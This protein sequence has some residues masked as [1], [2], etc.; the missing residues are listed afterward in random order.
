MSDDAIIFHI[1][2]DQDI[3]K[4]QAQGEYRCA[5]LDSEGFIHC[6]DRHQLA[7]VVNRYYQDSD[8]VQ[9]MLLDPDKL[10]YPLI[11]ENTMG[12]SELFPHIYG[13][14][15]KEAVRDIVPFGRSSTERQGL[16]E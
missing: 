16:A 8:D 6:C 14:I 15:N 2:S 13:I 10:Q 1:A 9:L 4:Y 12:G 7:G 11:R 5:S 3:E